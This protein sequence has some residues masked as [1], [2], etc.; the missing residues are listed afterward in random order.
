MN[1]AINFFHYIKKEESSYK[2]GKK[3]YEICMYFLIYL[4]NLTPQA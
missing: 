4:L 1:T 2:N 3:N